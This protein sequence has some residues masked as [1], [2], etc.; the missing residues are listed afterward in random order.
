MGD[1]QMHSISTAFG[2]ASLFLLRA[3]RRQVHAL[4]TACRFMER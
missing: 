4:M 1:P 2:G 3:F